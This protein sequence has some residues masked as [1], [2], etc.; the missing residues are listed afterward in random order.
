[1][2]RTESGLE[3][4]T[5]HWRHG[6]RGYYKENNNNCAQEVNPELEGTQTRVHAYIDERVA[7]E[8][9]KSNRE[10]RSNS[11]AM[12]RSVVKRRVHP[13]VPANRV[14]SGHVG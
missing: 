11:R 1:M 3:G 7:F 5:G 12:D 8:I 13:V 14:K 9:A 4:Q 6:E 10:L 2:Q